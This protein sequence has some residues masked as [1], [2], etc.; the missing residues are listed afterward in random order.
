MH[1][2][3]STPKMNPCQCRRRRWKKRSVK[4]SLFVQVV[5]LVVCSICGTL[6]YITIRRRAYEQF[7]HRKCDKDLALWNYKLH[8]YYINLDRSKARKLHIE[9]QLKRLNHNFSRWRASVPTRQEITFVKGQLKVPSKAARPAYLH[10]MVGVRKSNIK[11]LKHF[12]SV[13]KRGDIFLIFEDDVLISP[14]LVETLPC[15][16]EKVPNNWDTIRLDC[17]MDCKIKRNHLMY[18]GLNRKVYRAEDIKVPAGVSCI[19][20]GV[21][22][23][24]WFC[25]G[26]FATLHRFESLKDVLAIWETPPFDDHDC[27]LTTGQLNNYCVDMGLVVSNTGFQTTIPKSH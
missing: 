6:F 5:C 10:G 14:W 27:Q 23:N 16:I 8:I 22:D 9:T 18:P 2:N 12:L 25:G 11:L 17:L 26:G 13:G 4:L 19:C 24:C 1:R 20:G 7:L 21:P 15:V 3:A